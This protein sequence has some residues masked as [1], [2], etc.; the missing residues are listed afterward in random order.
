[1]VPPFDF[2]K[3]EMPF[4]AKGDINSLQN[5]IYKLYSRKSTNL[6]IV[7]LSC[8]NQR[9]KKRSN[10][11]FD[12]IGNVAGGLYYSRKKCFGLLQ[13]CGL[14]WHIKAPIRHKR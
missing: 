3:G 9:D 13:Y 4:C 1:M 6:T 5:K 7:A 2:V 10:G 12:G 14:C 11:F 8:K